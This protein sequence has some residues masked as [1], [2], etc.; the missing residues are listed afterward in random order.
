MLEG[1]EAQESPLAVGGC[2]CWY[3][4][5]P[6]VALGG[7]AAGCS[8]TGLGPIDG[9]QIFWEAQVQGEPKGTSATAVSVEATAYAL[10]H[11]LLQNNL[12]TAAKVVCWLTE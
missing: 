7:T 3:L 5:S 1:V 6:A 2:C 9:A 8:L 12:T 4:E 11:L 10:L